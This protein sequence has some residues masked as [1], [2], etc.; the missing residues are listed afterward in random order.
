[1][2]IQIFDDQRLVCQMEIDKT[3]FHPSILTIVGSDGLLHRESRREYGR[4]Y[5]TLLK[6]TEAKPLL[7]LLPPEIYA[8]QATRLVCQVKLFYPEFLIRVDPLEE[9]IGV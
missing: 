9:P 1:M 7:I 5:V 6:E 8:Y 3:P 2:V 4:E